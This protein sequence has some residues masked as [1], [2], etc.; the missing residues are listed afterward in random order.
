MSNYSTSIFKTIRGQLIALFAGIVLLVTTLITIYSPWQ[1]NNTGN[2]ILTQDA[3]YITSLLADNLAL[4]MKIKMFDNG[5]S[6]EQTLDLIRHNQKERY[7]TIQNVK[8]FTDSLEFITSLIPTQDK[9]ISKTNSLQIVEKNNLIYI[10]TPLIDNISGTVIGYSEITFSK[11]FLADSLKTNVIISSL[12]GFSGIVLLLIITWFIVSRYIVKPIQNLTLIAQQ[13]SHGE[14]IQKV[15]LKTNNEV[16]FLYDAFFE[17]TQQLRHHIEDLDEIV[18]QRTSEL[19]QQG[20]ELQLSEERFRLISET[21]PL[22]IVI[23]QIRDKKIIYSNPSFEALVKLNNNE[24]STKLISDFFFT[25]EDMHDIKTELLTN[26]RVITRELYCKNSDGTPLWLMVSIVLTKVDDELCAISGLIDV[27]ERKKTVEALESAKTSAEKA[28]S[29]KSAFLA[30]ISHELRTPLN[31]IIGFSQLLKSDKQLPEHLR[32]QVNSM[33]LSGNHLLEIIND[34][35]DISKIEA[36]ELELYPDHTKLREVAES[37]KS[38]M[39]VKAR[40]KSLYLHVE[41]DPELPESIIVDGKRF[42]QTLI[43][44]TGNAIKFTHKGGIII[45]LTKRE[46]DVADNVTIRCTVADTGRGIP[47]DE[48]QNIYIPFRQQQR[49]YSEGTGLGLAITQSILRKMESELHIESTEGVGSTFWFDIQT[50]IS[51]EN[52][53]KTD[54][55]IQEISVTKGTVPKVLVVDDL[56]EN[57]TFMKIA[58]ER[59]GMQVQTA[60]NGLEA[61]HSIDTWKPELVLMDIMMPVMNGIETIKRIRNDE[62]LRTLP[63]I[64][65]TADVLTN[66]AESLKEMGFTSSIS[67]PFKLEELFAQLQQHT[68]IPFVMNEQ[69]M[70]ESDEVTNKTNALTAITSWIAS[71]DTNVRTTLTDAI[72]LQDFEVVANIVKTAKLCGESLSAEKVLLQATENFDYHFFALLAEHISTLTEQH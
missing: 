38:M 59:A 63:V 12:I 20:K 4:G 26:G 7:S 11:E 13:I 21:L 53:S 24:L 56:Q 52:T 31:S 55:V 6:L 68:S 45:S 47:K 16:T 60:S 44:L 65:V 71:L 3:E 19:K 32:H 30:S 51:L 5:N 39:S 27:T 23:S 35:L 72:E 48:I 28:N 42:R 14:T 8:V 62:K 37:I 40:E 49:M 10:T 9:Q 2:K 54:I 46:N 64:A 70:K 58:L 43:N 33:N 61:L 18:D 1:A 50:P 22:P 29:A 41:V 57:I 15:E 34:I 69:T 36:G 25:L 66:S 67:K 17:M